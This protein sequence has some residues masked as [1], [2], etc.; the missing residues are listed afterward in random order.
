MIPDKALFANNRVTIFYDQNRK[1]LTIAT[2]S[3][4]NVVLSTGFIAYIKRHSS[5]AYLS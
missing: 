3:G 5:A 4:A 2:T 1:I